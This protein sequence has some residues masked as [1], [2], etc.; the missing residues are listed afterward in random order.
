MEPVLSKP[1]RFFAMLRMTKGEGIRM[2][3]SERLR[4]TQR[5][6]FQNYPTKNG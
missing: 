4:M 1:Y 6:I 5:K 3:E 2:T